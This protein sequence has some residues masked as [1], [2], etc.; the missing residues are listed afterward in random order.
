MIYNFT[1]YLLKLLTVQENIAS[2]PTGTVRL[3]MG[4]KNSGS[5]EVRVVDQS[6]E[7]EKIR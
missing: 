7:T 1:L 5:S 2:R 3:S 6:S 4:A